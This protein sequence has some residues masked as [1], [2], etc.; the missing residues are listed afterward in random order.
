MAMGQTTVTVFDCVCP[1]PAGV[2]AIP[3]QTQATIH[4]DPIPDL[5][6]TMVQYRPKP[7]QS[8]QGGINIVGVNGSDTSI[9]ITGLQPGTVYQ[10][11]VK[12]KCEI[13][14]LSP[15]TGPPPLTFTTTQ[16]KIGENGLG[17]E[18]FPNPTK[19]SLKI[20]AWSDKALSLIHI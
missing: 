15:F 14:V 19:Q 16:L 5:V 17:I 2:F 10:Y 3:G 13:N 20:T 7:N 9:T 8:A 18:L 1:Q 6:R 11:R 12:H 4:W